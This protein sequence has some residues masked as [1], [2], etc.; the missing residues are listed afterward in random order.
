MG[1]FDGEEDMKTKPT[2]Q[3]K[4][5]EVICDHYF[6]SDGP[7]DTCGGCGLKIIDARFMNKEKA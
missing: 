1:R 3:N 6:V 2:Q 5:I 7:G 4:K